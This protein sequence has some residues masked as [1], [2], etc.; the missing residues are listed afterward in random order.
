M[1]E[2]NNSEPSVLSSE[3]LSEFCIALREE[4]NA[5]RKNAASTAVPLVNGKRIAHLGS[6][7]QYVFEIENV[8]NLPGDTPGD[9]YVPNYKPLEIS[10]ISID[11]LTITLSVPIDLGLFVPTARLQSNLVHLMRKLIERIQDKDGQ[12][13]PSGDRIL[14]GSSSGEPVEVDLPECNEDQIAAVESS[15]GRNSTFIWGPPGTGKTR[16]IGSIGQQ[17]FYNNRSLLVVSHTNIAVDEALWRIADFLDDNV[18]EQGY[19]IRVGDT[20]DRRYENR[21][22]LLLSTHVERQTGKLNALLAEL[23][24]EHKTAIREISRVSHLLD[25][26]EWVIEAER[27]LYSMSADLEALKGQEGGLI[28]L[29]KNYAKMRK[30]TE[31][32]NIAI[33]EA[34]L[35]KENIKSLNAINNKISEYETLDLETNKDLEK[36]NADLKAAIA[37]Y[38]ESSSK[39]WLLRQW[40]KLPSPDFQREV[41]DGIRKT[42]YDVNSKLIKIKAEYEKALSEKNTLMATI[43]IF[44]EKYS[45]PPDNVIKKAE[46]HEFD[47]LRLKDT[48]LDLNRKCLKNRADL[49]SL[50]KNRL[51]L[52]REWGLIEISGHTAE[53]MLKRL[54]AGMKNAK[55]K[56]ADFDIKELLLKKSKLEIEIREIETKIN[57]IE[58]DLKRVEDIIISKAKIVATT[59]TRAYL[60]DSIQSRRFDTVILDEASMA[61]I[62]ALWIAAGL[63][64]ANVIV[65]GDFYQ[66]PPIVQSD[67]KL[68]LQWLGNDIFEI[69]GLSDLRNSPLYFIKLRKQYRMHPSICEIPNSFFY[70]YL[71]ESDRKTLNDCSL[72]NW[73]DFNWGYDKPVLLIDTNSLGAWVTSVPGGRRSS[74]LNFLSAT[75]C[76][77]VAKKLLLEDRQK[78]P[79]NDRHRILIVCPY[80][81]HAQ[82]LRILIDEENIV[83]D[84][85][86]GTA[87][88]FQGSEADIVVFDLVNDEPHWRVAMFMQEY[89]HSTKRLLNVALTRARRRLIIIGDFQ[90]IMQHSKKAF[91]GSELIPFLIENYPVVDAKEIISKGF[92]SRSAQIQSKIFGGDIEA[93][94]KR[95][96]VKQDKFYSIIRNDFAKSKARIII[97]SPFI[98]Q[99]KIGQ[100]EPQIRSAI[101]RGL[102][103]YIVTKA[104]SDRKKSELYQYRML[105]GTLEDWGAIVIHKR[106]MH[107]KLIFIDDEI[108][109]SGSL[110]PLSFR[111]TQEVMERRVSKRVVKDY[112][113]TIC[114]NELV[115][116]FENSRPLCPICNNEMIASEGRDE[117]FYWRCIEDGC[118]TRSID[119]PP[120]E[121]GRIKCWNCGSDVEY[122]NWGNNPAWR[123]LENRRHH[124]RIARSHL[125][126]PEMRNIIPKKILRKLDIHFGINSK[127]KSTGDKNKQGGLF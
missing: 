70:D 101:E 17:F 26:Y 10:V 104:H 108:L 99:D 59:L 117:P 21:K 68:A 35:T 28:Q 106:G 41:V 120:L 44:E 62:P 18:L 52:L 86:S 16:T 72:G 56:I 119:Q 2:F 3:L 110:N 7:Y 15:L 96:V 105:E 42:V 84:V 63:A 118:Y 97:Y 69:S 98:T 88:S 54:E 45:T 95:I 66:L 47:K 61:P 77:D 91:M 5:V 93:D 112:A 76:I 48:I 124:Q 33:K 92:L 13:N 11:G 14:S 29:E 94:E 1:K 100:L 55:N 81:P 30:D 115:N 50:F 123:C 27:D 20:V 79:D 40:R 75:L 65:V 25:I 37:L 9:L 6:S 19:I 46:A 71:L 22:Q 78:L 113:N 114:L 51:E 43:N 60:R 38:K 73:Y 80:R 125:R 32:W 83:S 39:G 4:I 116:E 24:D 103:L 67:H 23:K 126:L 107:E 89:D 58:E 87:H 8:L 85:S 82:L 53:N 74:R 127:T 90:Y 122:G 109:W 121:G 49:E 12:P 31:K 111:D 102:L 57:S 36:A 34:Q 64:D